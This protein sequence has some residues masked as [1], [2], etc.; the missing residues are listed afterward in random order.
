MAV[1]FARGPSGRERGTYLQ[2]ETE[3]ADDTG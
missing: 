2:V 1:V 3:V